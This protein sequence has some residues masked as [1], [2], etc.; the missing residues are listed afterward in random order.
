MTFYCT[1][2]VGYPAGILLLS[3]H[4]L[5]ALGLE[6]KT[7]NLTTKVLNSTQLSDGIS[8]LIRFSFEK[9]FAFYSSRR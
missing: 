6:K 1:G 8:L 3:I 5:D 4:F 7:Q 2:H 9:Y